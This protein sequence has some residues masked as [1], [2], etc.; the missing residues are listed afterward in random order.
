[1]KKKKR[2]KESKK[3]E[4]YIHNGEAG[5]DLYSYSQQL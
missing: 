2:Y 4:K 5:I 1:M 3:I